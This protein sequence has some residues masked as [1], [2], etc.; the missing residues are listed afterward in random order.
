MH[1]GTFINNLIKG[2]WS[3]FQNLDLC[4]DISNWK[5]GYVPYEDIMLAHQAATGYEINKF[6]LELFG[7]NER[8][9]WQ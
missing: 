6:T 7:V 4:I 2:N 1:S 5:T 8:I 9:K 3:F